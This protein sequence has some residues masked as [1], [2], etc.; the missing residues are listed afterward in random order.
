M[1]LILLG[2]ILLIYFYAWCSSSD[3]RQLTADGWVMYHSPDCPFCVEHLT[4]LGWT[5]TIFINKVNCK[6]SPGLC[7]NE[8]INALPTW[9]NM[10]TGAVHEGLV[11][12][13]LLYDTLNKTTV[14]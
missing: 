2:V 13:A 7:S 1:L 5:K 14:L 6:S 11:E 9:K 3:I 10:K 12:P 4:A 8:K